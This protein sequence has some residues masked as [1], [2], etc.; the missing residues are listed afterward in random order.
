MRRNGK[1]V[2]GPPWLHVIKAFD[3]IKIKSNCS[4]RYVDRGR[5]DL[6][7]RATQGRSDEIKN[8]PVSDGVASY[9]THRLV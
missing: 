1:G 6:S 4:E 9:L 5:I 7:L 3:L 8:I 2:L